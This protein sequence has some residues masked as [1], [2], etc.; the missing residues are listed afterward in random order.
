MRSFFMFWLG[1][2]FGSTSGVV[3]PAAAAIIG[4]ILVYPAVDAEPS[5]FAAVDGSLSVDPA[6]FGKPRRR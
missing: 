5:A 4:A 2:N 1:G 3:A 6:V